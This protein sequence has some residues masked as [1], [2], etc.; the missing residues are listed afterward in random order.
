MLAGATMTLE[1]DAFARLAS[2][3]D[4]YLVEGRVLVLAR[5]VPDTVLEANLFAM[6]SVKLESAKFAGGWVRGLRYSG[7]R[8]GVAPPV[9]VVREV[10]ASPGRFFI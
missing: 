5:D 10:A 8:H 3:T 6:V 9:A 4:D 1:I 2:A 7:L